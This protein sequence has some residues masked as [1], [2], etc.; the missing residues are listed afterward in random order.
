MLQTDYLLRQRLDLRVCEPKDSQLLEALYFVRELLHGVVIE[1]QH[2]KRVM[3]VVF[4][5]EKKVR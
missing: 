5:L 2:L 3:Q 1:Q 4:W